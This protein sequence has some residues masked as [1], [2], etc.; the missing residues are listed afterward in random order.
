MRHEAGLSTTAMML[1]ATVD[2]LGGTTTPAEIG[3]HVPIT[4][5]AITSLL[6]TNEKKGLVV[7]SPH[8]GDRRKIQVTLTNSGRELVDRLL[9]AIHALESEVM[10]VLSA[11]E[12]TILLAI[13][14]KVQQSIVTVAVEPPVLPQANRIRPERLNATE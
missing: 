8:P 11:Q 4:S 7:R 10:N 3:K 14:E 9:P 2:G 1:L 6:D 5:A 12:K 13:L